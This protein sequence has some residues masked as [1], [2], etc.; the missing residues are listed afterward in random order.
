[1]IQFRY[2]IIPRVHW[3]IA[4]L[5]EVWKLT[6]STKVSVY[7]AFNFKVISGQNLKFKGHLH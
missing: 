2:L 3:K 5:I 7:L 1:M 4:L 6:V